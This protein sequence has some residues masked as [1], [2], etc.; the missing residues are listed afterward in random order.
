MSPGEL[1]LDVAFLAIKLDTHGSGFTATVVIEGMTMK[2]DS[3]LAELA[4]DAAAAHPTGIMV[5]RSAWEGP[6]GPR[7]RQVLRLTD[8][9]G[10]RLQ[11]LVRVEEY[12]VFR[13]TSLPTEFPVLRATS[14]ATLEQAEAI[15]ADFELMLSALD[16]DS[17]TAGPSRLHRL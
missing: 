7:L 8:R 2:P 16:S 1:N 14:T 10:P 3:S 4:D 17:P 12:A 9:A 11:R 6:R 5:G 15:A 13:E